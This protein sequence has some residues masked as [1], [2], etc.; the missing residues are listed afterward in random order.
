MNTHTLRLGALGLVLLA[1]SLTASAAAP[2][3]SAAEASPA[4]AASAPGTFGRRDRPLQSPAVR[5][6]Q[7]AASPGDLRPE[8]PVVPQ[9]TVQLRRPNVNHRAASGAALAGDIDDSAARCRAA[10]ST[11]QREACGRGGVPGSPKR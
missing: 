4:P 3:A 2:A 7:D 6:A 10:A 5:A 11:R 1:A 9:I 8:N